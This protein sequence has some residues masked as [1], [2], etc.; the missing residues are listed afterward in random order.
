[1]YQ[2]AATQVKMVFLFARCAL[3]VRIAC[4]DVL[5]IVDACAITKPPTAMHARALL[6]TP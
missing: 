5:V 1:M 3:V 2:I 4:P 6:T